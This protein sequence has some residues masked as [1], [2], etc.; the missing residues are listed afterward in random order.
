MTSY[1]YGI[2]EVSL[3]NEPPD[4]TVDFDFGMQQN[5]HTMTEK[6]LTELKLCLH[7]LYSFRT[8]VKPEIGWT[9]S[10]AKVT[11]NVLMLSTL[12]QSTGQSALK[13]DIVD[14]Q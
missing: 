1:I 4:E 3:W 7:S 14:M 12:V 8:L 11:G 10:E 9:H 5:P 2:K 13:K 6:E